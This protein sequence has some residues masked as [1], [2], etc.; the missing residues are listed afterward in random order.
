MNLKQTKNELQSVLSGKSIFSYDPV[1]QTIAHKLRTSQKA[2]PVAEE[3]HKNKNQ[4]TAFLKEFAAKHNLFVES[5]N[6]SDF[7]SKGAEQKVYIKDNKHVIK[8]NDAI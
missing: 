7:I 2:S 5:I 4:E 6:K 3:K 8:L 1:I